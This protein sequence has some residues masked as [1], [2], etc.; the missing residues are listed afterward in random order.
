VAIPDNQPNGIERTL[1]T[2]AAGRVRSV[3]VGVDITHTY[4][5]DLSVALVSPAGT[6]VTLHDRT[7][8]D[9]D[10]LIVTHTPATL[11]GLDRLRGEPIA[12]AW[13][14]QVADREAVDLGKLNRWS[15]EI[16]GES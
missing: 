7:G 8:R 2:A 10:N 12:G 9:A 6:R 16:T 11:P 3:E 15:L 1:V 4:I 14:L 5:G 13:K